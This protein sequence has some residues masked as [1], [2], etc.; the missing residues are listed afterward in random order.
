MLRLPSSLPCYVPARHPVYCSCCCIEVQASH[1]STRL[2][3][4]TPSLPSCLQALRVLARLENPCPP[5]LPRSQYDAWVDDIVATKF[6]YVVSS[7][8]RQPTSSRNGSMR[9]QFVHAARVQWSDDQ[10]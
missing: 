10:H 2:T 9:L 7:Q 4:P 6:Q 5:G 8:V 3:S 1:T